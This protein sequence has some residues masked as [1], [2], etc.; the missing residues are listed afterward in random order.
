M[1]KSKNNILKK[2]AKFYIKGASLSEA[3][4]LQ[5]VYGTLGE[6]AGLALVRFF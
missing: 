4:D 6:R 5:F 3:R 1:V 2:G